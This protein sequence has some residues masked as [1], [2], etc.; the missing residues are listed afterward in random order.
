MNIIPFLELPALICEKC[1]WHGFA[2]P[3]KIGVQYTGRYHVKCTNAVCNPHD[4][5]Y[6]GQ[7]KH[8]EAA[9]K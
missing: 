4:F 9:E 7:L 6:H 3:E 1:G 8:A 5:G 2:T